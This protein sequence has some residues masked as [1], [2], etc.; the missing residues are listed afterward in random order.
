MDTEDIDC[1]VQLIMIIIFQKA[2]N[3]K[4]ILCECHV[5]SASNITGKESAV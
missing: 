5:W 2:S 4:W 3:S 1:V